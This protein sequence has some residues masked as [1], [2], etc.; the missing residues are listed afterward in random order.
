MRTF[1][2]PT[3]HGQVGLSIAMESDEVLFQE[4]LA[5]EASRANF[6]IVRL[7]FHMS[8]FVVSAISN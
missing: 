4:V 7:I 8:S 1:E 3:I 2:Q 6:T 5:V